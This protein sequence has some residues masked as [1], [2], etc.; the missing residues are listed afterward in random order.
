[1]DSGEYPTYLEL[2]NEVFVIDE[3]IKKVEEKKWLEGRNLIPDDEKIGQYDR[4]LKVLNEAREHVTEGLSK[5][6]QDFRMVK[7]SYQQY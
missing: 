1:M 4:T 2:L 6:E 5:Y 3:E 7:L